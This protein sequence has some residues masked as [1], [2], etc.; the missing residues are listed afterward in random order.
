MSGL[1]ILT[2]LLLRLRAVTPG[3]NL[4][5]DHRQCQRLAS[6]LEALMRR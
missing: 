3:N 5:I 2:F 1:R 4:V 6:A